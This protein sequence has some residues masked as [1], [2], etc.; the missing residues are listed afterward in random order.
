MIECCPNPTVGNAATFGSFA[1]CHVDYQ[2]DCVVLGELMGYVN[3]LPIVST[4]LVIVP[5]AREDLIVVLIAIQIQDRPRAAE[6]VRA[7]IGFR[8]AHLRHAMRRGFGELAAGSAEGVWLTVNCDVG[9][10]LRER[11]WS[12][13]TEVASTSTPV[14]YWRSDMWNGDELWPPGEGV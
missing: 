13:G 3:G 10:D 14:V 6:D 4:L 9:V 7:D 1:P 8:V 11:G 2:S 5:S 12:R